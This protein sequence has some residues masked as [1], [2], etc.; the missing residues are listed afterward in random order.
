MTFVDI[1][2]GKKQ[3]KSWFLENSFE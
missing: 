1:E 3:F 2:R